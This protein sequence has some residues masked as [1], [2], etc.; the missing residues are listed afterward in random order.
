MLNTNNKPLGIYQFG[1]KTFLLVEG[2]WSRLNVAFGFVL[3]C[4]SV[5]FFLKL[6]LVPW[7][8]DMERTTDG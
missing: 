6:A 8:Q 4:S 1:T 3:L 7:R 5:T 2:V